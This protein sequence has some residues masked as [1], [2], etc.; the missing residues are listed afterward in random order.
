MENNLN[1]EN[2]NFAKQIDDELDLKILFAFYS[3]NKF[4]IGIIVLISFLSALLGSLFLKKT[5]EGQFQIVLNSD[6]KSKLINLNPTLS[7]LINADANNNDN[8]KTQVGILESPF[9]LRPIYE[10]V[11]ENNDKDNLNQKSY[12]SWKSNLE[13]GLQK[14]TS[15][16][17]ISYRDTDKD[18][19]LPVLRK[20]SS[21]YQD[22]SGS[23]TKKE[24]ELTKKYLIDQIKLYKE[25]STQSLNAVQNFAIDQNLVYLGVNDYKSSSKLNRSAGSEIN[26]ADFNENFLGFSE[27]IENTRVSAANQLKMINN[28]IKQINEL[29]PLESE[30]LQY[31]GSSIPTLDQEGL[32]QR[33]NDIEIKLGL[34]R[35]RYTDDDPLI[36]RLEQDKESIAKLLK[37]SAIK[38]LQA[39][40]L[41][42]EARMEAA[43]RPKGVLLKYR[44]L[45]REAARDE[46]TLLSLENDLRILKLEEAKISEPWKLITKPTLLKNYVAPSKRI[47]SIFG[48]VF[49]LLLGGLSAY[50]KEQKSD[51]ISTFRELKKIL[52]TPFLEKL[53]KNE[54]LINSEQIIFLSEFLKYQKSKNIAFLTLEEINSSYLK[55]LREFLLNETNIKIDIRVITSQLSLEECTNSDF[56]LL[57]TSLDYASRD[58]MKNLKSRFKLLDINLKGF[59]LLDE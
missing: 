1:S 38:Y 11:I 50:Y 33:L 55:K 8:L 59:I 56:T 39:E 34:F 21:A 7:S 37:S 43:N 30:K 4:L 5:W 18:I 17:N 45:R 12:K 54:N 2:S 20:M 6:Q 19:I 13:I 40:K 53:N 51:R 22:Y 28:L 49:G 16:L 52:T 14:G 58:Q 42:A 23:T 27:N 15:I 31:F 47:Y 36:I 32:P 26:A 44:E 24:Q 3:R 48:L 57:F 9:V 25:K 41:E 35:S 29:G 10:L 46:T